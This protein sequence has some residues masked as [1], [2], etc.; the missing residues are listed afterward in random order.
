[1]TAETKEVQGLFGCGIFK[2]SLMIFL[3][4]ATQTLWFIAYVN[5]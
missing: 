4:H 3:Y 2:S 1:M 5:N